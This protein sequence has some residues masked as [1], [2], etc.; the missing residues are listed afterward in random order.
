MGM[1]TVQQMD[2]DEQQQLLREAID[3]INN[4]IVVTDPN[5]PDNPIIYV[6]RGFEQLIGYSRDEAL[7]RNYRFLQGD[8]R[9]QEATRRLR[10]AISRGE[11]SRVELR[12]YRK[13]GT[14]FWNEL[15]VS[16]TYR[17]SRLRY[18]FGVQNDIT[19]RK[20]LEASN[21]HLTR[22]REQM[23]EVVQEVMSDT[24]WFSHKVMQRLA[25]LRSGAPEDGRPVA[26]SRRE[27]QVLERLAKALGNETIAAEL[28]I[29]TQ[30]VR[31]YI[32]TIYDKLGVHSRAEAIIWA[33]ERGILN[34]PEVRSEA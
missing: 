7:G 13:D 31:N 18:F 9:E 3:A 21:E 10:G 32:S 12:N 24:G 16:P 30:T 28:G 26:L 17:E 34:K 29:A 19:E 23:L 22:T 1:A 6:N 27:Q 25:D 2:E 8:D 11:H 33:R 15:Y 20:A 4:V 5:L 14:L